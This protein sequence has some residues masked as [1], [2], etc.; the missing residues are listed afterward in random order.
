MKDTRSAGR[1]VRALAAPTSA[2]ETLVETH[3]L[4]PEAERYLKCLLAKQDVRGT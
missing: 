4:P 2:R 1:A 3:R